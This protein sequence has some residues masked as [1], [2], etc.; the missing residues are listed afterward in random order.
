MNFDQSTQD[1]KSAAAL[2]NRLRWITA[3]GILLLILAVGLYF[4]NFSGHFAETQEIWGQFGD[5]LGGTLNPLFSLLALIALL[6]T[7]ALQISEHR[8]S[9]QELRNSAKALTDQHFVMRKQ[10]FETSFFQLINLHNTII[11]G[12]DLVDQDENVTKG[13][14]C[15]A[16]FVRR[17][18][19]QLI[20][21]PLVTITTDLFEKIYQDFYIKAERE[22]AHYFQMLFCILTFIKDTDTINKRF[23]ADIV[24][25]QLSS[26]EVTLLFY[27]CLSKRHGAKLKPLIEEFSL[28]ENLIKPQVSRA[29]I[30]SQISHA[31]FG[32]DY[33]SE[34]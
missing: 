27:H 25:A 23:Y 18:N 33:P 26:P 22:I 4:Y 7:F 10:S 14:D 34:E 28:L 19:P 2:F 1:E 12:I 29:L 16:V 9:T 6:S 13:R 24:R 5:F 31:A 20:K 32:N 30:M 11:N 8:V 17:I 15:F 3:T 21:Y